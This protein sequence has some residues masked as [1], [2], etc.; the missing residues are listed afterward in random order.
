[1]A[2][3][4]AG[5]ATVDI[6]PS[7]KNFQKKIKAELEALNLNVS[8][9][10]DPDLK[11]FDS[12]MAK[13]TRS[14]DTLVKVDADIAKA[15]AKL[16]ELEKGRTANVNADAD[17]TKAQAKLDALTRKREVLLQ[18]NADSS[19]AASEIDWVARDRSSTIRVSADTS[20]ADASISRMQSKIAAIGGAIALGG[21]ALP[22]LAVAAGG[23]LTAL[24]ASLV[25]VSAALKDY[26]TAADTAGKSTATL[27]KETAQFQASLNKLSPA[28]KDFTLGLIAAKDN[29]NLFAKAM[30]QATLP[31]FTQFLNSVQTAQGPLTDGFAAVG[32]SISGVATRAG[33]LVANPL[34][35][36]QID[37]ALR[38]SSVI[39][40]QTGDGIV[41][42]VQTMTSF[43]DSSYGIIK[44]T[45]NLI[46]SALGGVSLYLDNVSAHSDGVGQ[47]FTSLGNIIKTVLGAAGTI[48]GQFGDA[49]ASVKD[50]VERFVSSATATITQF[51][52]GA[53]Q[54]LA[55]GFKVLLDVGSNLLNVLG[56]LASTLGGMGANLLTG[57]TAFRLLSGAVGGA[58]AALSKLNPAKILDQ[59][60]SS[61]VGKQV[62]KLGATAKA[63]G[64]NAGGLATGLASAGSKALGLLSV[65][66]LLGVAVAGIVS[67]IKNGT[68]DI[69]AFASALE[70][71]GF[72]AADAQTKITA[73]QSWQ[74]YAATLTQVKGINGEVTQGIGLQKTVMQETQAVIDANNAKLSGLELAQKAVTKAQ[75]DL[76]Y[77]QKTFGDQSP[78]AASAADQL[79]TATSRLK[80]QQDLAANATKSHTEKMYDQQLQALQT[81]GG[82]A[83]LEAA[84]LSLERAQNAVADATAKGTLSTIEGR[85]AQ[86]DLRQ[87][88]LGV[89]SASADFGGA[90]AAMNGNLDENTGKLYGSTA[91]ILSVVQASKD[92]A[93]PAIQS[94]IASLDRS[95]LSALGVSEQMTWTGQTILSFPDGKDFT[96][97][98]NIPEAQSALDQFAT[99]VQS[100]F[101]RF[102]GDTLRLDFEYRLAN[103][104]AA[105]AHASGGLIT[106]PG[107]GTSDSI[108][109]MLS[110]G[111]YIINAA[112][113]SRNLPLLH[114]LNANH[115]ATGGLVGATPSSTPV[116][117]TTVT[118]AS[119]VL[120]PAVFANLTQAAATLGVQ[121][122]TLV[123]QITGLVNPAFDQMSVTSSVTWQAMTNSA[124]QSLVAHT[125]IFN[126]LT[127]GFGNI[128]SSLQYTADWAVSQ[129]DRMREAAAE[130][131]RYVINGPMN[132]GIIAA[133]NQLNDDFGLGKSVAPIPLQ[134]ASGGKVLGPGTGTSDSIPARLSNGEFVVREKITSR[135]APFLTALNDG[136][137]EALQAAGFATGGLVDIHGQQV[138]AAVA[139]ALAFAK[140]QDGKPYIWG[141]VGPAGY[142]CSGYMSAVTNVLRGENP[143]KRLGVAASE[144]WAGFVPG[145]SS[146][147]GMG[148]SSSHTAGTLAGVNLESTG[149]HV[150]YGG[151]AHGATDSQF[152][153]RSSLPTA[154]GQFVGGGLGG[155]LDGG[156]LASQA[157]ANASAL[158]SGVVGRFPGNRMADYAGSI[159]GQAVTG[160]QGAAA[161]ALNALLAGPS[162]GAGVER[163]RGVV[164]QALSRVG[165]DPGNANSTL[166]RM[167]QES[168]GNQFAV[169]NW[170]IN[171]KNGVPSKGLMQVID[172]TFQSYRDPSL[173]PDIFNPLANIVASMRYALGRYGSLS[174]AYNKAG[175][176]TDGG[177]VRDNADTVP[178]WLTPGERVLTVDQNRTF[179]RLVA[180]L[181]HSDRLVASAVSTQGGSQYNMPITVYGQTDA[182]TLAREAARQIAFQSR[183]V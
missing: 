105:S 106:G 100:V 85:Q 49:F 98:T 46:Q 40:T 60:S 90:L 64:E 45:A 108:P 31:G 165:Q 121:L 96:L 131:V 89:V 175:G 148:A 136:Q 56:P 88:Q 81:A 112:A 82:A 183:N 28:A 158:A 142:D 115:Y 163:W 63:A 79:A 6:V 107:T 144:P 134:F 59:L 17:V 118:G 93:D 178:A 87:A 143:Y 76:T 169:N 180:N 97:T 68:P 15:K 139:S 109:A 140:Q 12:E 176:Y 43:T 65:A 164:M 99:D 101:D 75:N 161:N 166:R 20:G 9:E 174:A 69:N 26:N 141:G 78:Q 3:Y 44:G 22:G 125:A 4:T 152:S 58:T 1:M 16:D 126:S 70:K 173:S 74:T 179:E 7:L 37:R 160:A 91:A 153:V 80:T 155:F 52:H 8:V 111:E 151:D 35:Q 33:E 32:A 55:D 117:G 138:G 159:A 94:L 36:G 147:F 103:K 38:N 24:V 41:G 146:L 34:F 104:D 149:T 92:Q 120:D 14:R 129:W 130:P 95:A 137:P 19:K 181:S 168:G 51:T 50:S 66:P 122:T 47:T 133:W 167:N 71:G 83:G 86:L 10:V 157:F 62:D 61:A 145:L 128:R 170:D 124:N 53:F 135:V 127:N 13:A 171:A 102:K 23:G 42:L 39:I 123:Q 30:Q 5:Q 77:A 57:V 18:V 48:V 73:A 116:A 72:A 25:P 150:R 110:N 84:Q 113:T 172:P 27:T 119:L 29:A 114:A 154:G 132:A 156:T 2:K 67:V 177:T 54:G 11:K 21:A 162:G 182:Q